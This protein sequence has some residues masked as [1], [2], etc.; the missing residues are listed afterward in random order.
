MGKIID[1]VRRREERKAVHR[2]ELFAE[3]HG[4]EVIRKTAIAL[5]MKN[6]PFTG[7]PFDV[8]PWWHKIRDILMPAADTPHKRNLETTP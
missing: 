6:D 8:R 7:E 3:E 1:R 5:G 2:A 4:M